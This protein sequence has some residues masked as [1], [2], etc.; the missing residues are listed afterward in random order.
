MAKKIAEKKQHKNLKDG[1]KAVTNAK[2]KIAFES[3][4]EIIK[5]LESRI[6]ELENGKD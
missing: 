5:D 1:V 6:K 4:L 3:L 2:V